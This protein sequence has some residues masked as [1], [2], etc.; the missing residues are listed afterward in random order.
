[1][2]QDQWGRLKQDLLKSVGKSNFKS[3]IEPLE[4]SH[5]EEGVATFALVLTI[6][7]TI[8]ARPEA[9]PLPSPL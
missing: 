3:W 7:G 9:V 6:I 2:K 8:R 5:I 4:L 1:M